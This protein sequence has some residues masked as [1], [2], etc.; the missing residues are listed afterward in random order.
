MLYPTE[1]WALITVALQNPGAV[2]PG[3]DLICRIGMVKK[4]RC[5][6]V[7]RQELS[8]VEKKPLRCLQK[9]GDRVMLATSGVSFYMEWVL[10]AMNWSCSN[11]DSELK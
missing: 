7:K 6:G 4:L 10:R 11:F 5:S 9:G 2:A 3:E 8:G 1:L